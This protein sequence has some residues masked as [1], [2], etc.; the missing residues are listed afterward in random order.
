[1][2]RRQAEAAPAGVETFI[3]DLQNP[4]NRLLFEPFARV[5]FMGARAGG[6]FCRSQR[7]G[8]GKCAIESKAVADIDSEDGERA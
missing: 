3:F 8:I 6:K 5:A 2:S 4:G 1:M 7:P